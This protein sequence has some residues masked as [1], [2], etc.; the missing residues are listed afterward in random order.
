MY[1]LNEAIRDISDIVSGRS[2]ISGDLR[3]TAGE[4]QAEGAARGQGCRIAHMLVQAPGMT[5]CKKKKI[6]LKSI[7]ASYS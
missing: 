7:A 4:R 3:G 2:G 6:Y 1:Q 5:S